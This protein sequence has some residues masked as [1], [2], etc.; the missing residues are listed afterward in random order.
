MF[1]PFKR[2]HK[3]LWQPTKA[4]GFGHIVEEMCWGCGKYRKT[5]LD[6]KISPTL[7]EKTKGNTW[8]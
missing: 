3:H 5:E 2:K 7:N 4:N 1:N 8:N 6:K